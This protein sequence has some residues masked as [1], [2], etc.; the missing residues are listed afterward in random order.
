MSPK[1][2]L[3][4]FEQLVLLSI[5]QLRDN[6]YAPNISRILDERANREVSRGA[7]Y[8]T[9]DRLASK[10]HVEWDIQAATSRR[11]GS[12]RRL[13][14]VTPQGVDALTVSQQALMRLRQGLEST[15]TGGLR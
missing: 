2:H 4:E 3:G 11:R 10:Q 8:A 13:F 1:D 7:L 15:L 6:A 5:L 9:L 14:S 12:R